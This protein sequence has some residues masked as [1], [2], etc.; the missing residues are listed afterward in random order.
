[1]KFTPP[2]GLVR[3]SADR[4]WPARRVMI[5]DTRR[6]GSRRS[7]C[8]TS[9]S[10]SARPWRLRPNGDDGLGLGL[11]IAKDLVEL[12][13]G[14]ITVHSAGPGRGSTFTVSLPLRSHDR[15]TALPSQTRKPR[16]RPPALDP[17]AACR[18][19]SVDTD[20]ARHD[21]QQFRRRCCR[22]GA[23]RPTRRRLYSASSHRFS[24]PILRCRATTESCSCRRSDR[25]AARFRR[26]P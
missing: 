2:G 21:P 13:G 24:S 11:A 1:M 6:T 9:S 22:R 8:R 4:L 26:S 10:A 16:T 19:R 5:E 14:S 12:H 23:Q 7:S 15:E 3:L 18:G 25:D 20:A 17:R